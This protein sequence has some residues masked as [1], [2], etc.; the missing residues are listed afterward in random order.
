MGR[1][2]SSGVCVWGGGGS[3]FSCILEERGRGVMERN[4]EEGEEE[5]GES[6]GG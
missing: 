6:T 1:S 4:R 3:W 5:E 2:S